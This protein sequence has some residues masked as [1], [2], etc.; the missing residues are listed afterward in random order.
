MVAARYGVSVSYVVK[1][2]ARLRDKGEATPGAQRCHLTPKLAPETDALRA[3]V[4]AV[5]DA[6]LAELQSWLRTE[7][8]IA[9]GYGTLWRALARLGL[10]L[11]KRPSRPPSRRARPSPLPA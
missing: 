5:P 9:V 1:A 6:T 4:A 11:K 10:T 8:G 2:R 7:R 3:R